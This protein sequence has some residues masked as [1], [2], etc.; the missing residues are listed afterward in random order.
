MSAAGQPG[1]PPGWAA[2][3]LGTLLREPLRN[4][5]SARARKD[6]KGVRTLT[7]TAVTVGDFSE[8]N[9]KMTAADPGKVCDLWLQPGDIF[10][11]R[12][13]TPDLVGTAKLYT[14]P[15]NFAIFPDLLIRVRLVPDVLPPLLESYLH[16]TEARGYFKRAAQGIAGS[17][18]KISQSTIEALR[19]PVPPLP[20]Q[21]RI[22]EAIESYFTRLDDAVAT[23]ERVQ[24]N[25]KRYRASVLKSA[26]EGRLVPTEADLAQAE[27]RDYEP[28]SVLLDRILE[29]RRRR[30]VEA[31]KRG[32][33][34]EP[35]K[36]DTDGLP[37]LPEGW[38][39]AAVDQVLAPQSKG[40]VEQGWSPK[41]ERAAAG[42]DEWGVMKTTAV[43]PMR[44][45][46][47]ENKRLPH[48]LDPKPPLEIRVGDLIITRAGPR[49]RAGIACMVRSVR[50]KLLL[51]DKAYR[52]RTAP[53]VRAAY[54][55]MYLNA[56]PTL[57]MLERLKTG[58]SDSG[59]N[60]TQKRFLPMPL[61]LP[62]RAEQSR[63]VEAVETQ[64][65]VN[66]ALGR[67]TGQQL[68]RCARL[69]Q[70]ILKWAFEGKL[71]DQDPD[72]EPA[73]ALLDRI[74]AERPT[75]RKTSRRGRRSGRKTT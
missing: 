54:V 2:T 40:S 53:G 4:G 29:E 16:S 64:I 61:A 3:P 59:V 23:L 6:G 32:K 46:D 7:L 21:H 25:L 8:R 19:V 30:W 58:I 52:F 18:P 44:F 70:S 56:P 62:P 55:E 48:K 72:D 73:A 75:A 34:K 11:E 31:G 74:K 33:Y 1:V 49:K 60:L 17:M 38:V 66:D 69:R 15:A 51:C 27:G 9:T 45:V 42:E 67:S 20:E 63:I 65:S 24:A 47:A 68:G 43:Q 37:E 5:H 36:P 26:V 35:V 71:V 10:V 22:V 41:C 13:N 57:D 50:P 28:A 39:W 14:G 12:S